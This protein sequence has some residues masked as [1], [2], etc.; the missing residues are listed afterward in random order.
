MTTSLTIR[1]PKR[2][3]PG[4]LVWLLVVL[5]FSFG[6]LMDLLGLPSAVKYL[7]DLSWLSA[8]VYLLRFYRSL[9][10]KRGKG[11]FLWASVFFLFT[12]AV[13]PV[14]YQSGLYYLWGIRNNFRFYVAFAAFAAFLTPGDGAAFLGMFDRLF[15]INA[16][17]SAVQFLCF[18]LRG[19]Y[20]GGIFGAEQGCNAYTNLFFVIVLTKSVVHCLEKKEATPVCL[21]KCAAALLVAG[22][23]ELKFFFIEFGAI[24]VLAVLF[25][26]FTWRKLWLLLGGTAGIL[27]GAALVAALFP[28]YGDWFRLDWILEAASADRGYTSSGDLNRLNAIA[29]INEKIFGH[30]GQRWFGLGLGN[31]DTASFAFLDTP[32]Y[33]TYASLHYT[34]LSTAFWYLETGY[35]GLVFFFG[36]FLLIFFCAV[37]LEKRSR[38]VAKTWCRMGKIMAVLCVLIAI[39]N[40]S[41]RTEAGY[42]AYFVL[43]LPFVGDRE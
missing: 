37:R 36:F 7:L 24:L 40:S 11:M 32:F 43:A 39:Y 41:L 34:W 33:Q 19:D 30:W 6:M 38:G 17:V 22:L 3:Q 21:A 42:M 10:L 23:A 31:C 1:L 20:L 13:Y 15:W 5:P 35:L 28:G 27:A 4:W 16:A 12:L 29:V 2:S 26:G 25:T 9:D 14:R 8:L 18:G